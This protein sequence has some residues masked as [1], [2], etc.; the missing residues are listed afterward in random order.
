LD[1]FVELRF[2]WLFL[3]ENAGTSTMVPIVSAGLTF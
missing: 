1:L 3:K 2:N